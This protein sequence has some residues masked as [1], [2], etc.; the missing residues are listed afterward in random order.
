MNQ[1]PAL[2]QDDISRTALRFLKSYYRQRP[3]TGST[4]LSSDLRGAGGIIADGF[5]RYSTPEGNHFIATIEATSEA[6]RDEVVYKV[7]QTLLGWDAAALASSVMA[8][9]TVYYN[10]NGHLSLQYKYW[11]LYLIGIILSGAMIFWLY[12][13]LRARRQRYHYIYAIEQFKRY[14]ADEQWIALG[15][16]VFKLPDSDIFEL[17]GIHYALTERQ[18]RKWI[19][20]EERKYNELI[21]QCVRNGVGLLI[22][23]KNGP[24]IVKIT[25]SREDLFKN[26]RQRIQ[27]FSQT[28]ISNF[29]QMDNAPDWIKSFNAE[30]L[31][32]FQR[33]YKYQATICMIAALIFGAILYRE[34]SYTEVEYIAR[35]D[36]IQQMEAL[37]A[38]NESIKEPIYYFVDTPFVW[39]RPYLGE[40]QGYALNLGLQV[41]PQAEANEIIRNY[42]KGKQYDV[43]MTFP[44]G[45]DDLIVYD[46]SRLYNMLG[47]S[48]IVQEGIYDSYTDAAHR[49][50]ELRKFGYETSGLL[51]D[52]FDEIEKGYAVYFG[53]VFKDVGEAQR[54][55]ATYEALLGDNVLKINMSLR[56]LSP[57]KE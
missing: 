40:V 32:R 51:L 37:M 55:L 15:E 30:N 10:F 2:N 8:I 28:E 41:Y 54:A 21:T 35:E 31:M 4:E 19:E 14:H 12:T 23:R 50:S 20:D 44:E 47:T 13:K 6:S 48:Y 39:P 24:P 43:F 11:W 45:M 57:N 25:P 5:L 9:A 38:K 56:S 26:K 18:K 46:C 33:K 3:R 17:D 34:L 49:I 1:L 27:L 29:I 52:C 42:Q 53:L 36:Y 16:D 22:V 7:Q